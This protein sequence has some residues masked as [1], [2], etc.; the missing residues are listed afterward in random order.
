MLFRSRLPAPTGIAL[1]HR[2]RVPACKQSGTLPCLLARSLARTHSPSPPPGHTPT[3]HTGICLTRPWNAT[4]RGGLLVPPRI[5]HSHPVRSTVSLSFRSHLPRVVP[6]CARRPGRRL[7]AQ[8]RSLGGTRPLGP[9]RPG[10]FPVSLPCLRGKSPVKQA[11]FL[12]LLLLPV[13]ALL[14]RPW[15]SPESHVVLPSPRPPLPQARHL[16]HRQGGP[17]ARTKKPHTT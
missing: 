15:A 17:Q 14:G 3:R 8:A 5:P 10:P 16:A 6:V 13:P 12:C 9:C 7:L 2:P 11:P 4:P 1:C